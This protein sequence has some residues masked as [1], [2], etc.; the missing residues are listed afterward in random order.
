[1]T[2]RLRTFG[3]VYIE[4]DGTPLGGAHSQRRRLAL[5]AYLAAAD[6]VAVRREKLIALLWPESDESSA[7]HSL[8]QLLYALRHDLG[9]DAIAVDAETV[10]LDPNVVASDARDFEQALREGRFGDAVELYRGAFLEDFHV[11]DAPD[12]DRWI[13]TER[14]RLAFACARALDR[15]AQDAETS[16][17]FHRAVEWL[18]RRVALDPADAR[19]TLK[20]MQA[21]AAIGDRDGALRVARVYQS[22]LRDEIEAEPDPAIGRFMEELRRAP[23]PDP[24]SAA[25]LPPAV[26]PLRPQPG[27]SSSAP[28]A[29]PEPPARISAG[30]RIPAR[31]V[32]TGGIA[33][34]LL[35]VATAL[36]ARSR[37]GASARHADGIALVVIGD[38]EGPDGA[39]ALAVR[40][41]L[42]AELV[43][44]S[45]VLLTSDH[46]IR[47]LRTLMRLP[48]DAPLRP[49]A[50]LTLANRA[51]A[52]VAITGSVVPV[53][54]GAQI[55]LELLD[56]V[57]MRPI[58]TFSER[59]VDGA[60]TLAAVDRLA[61]LI[62][63][64]VSRAPRDTSVR[65]LPAVTTSSLPALK[66]Y[67]QARQTAARGK[68]QEAIAPA[69]R[70]VTHD[71][72][73][74]LAHYLLGDVLW[75]LDEQT[76]SEAHLSKAYELSSTVPAREQLVI[77]ARYEQLAR[78]RPDSALVYWQMVADAW[79]GDVHAYEGRS[80]AL[81]AL[82]RHEEAAAAADTAMSLDPGALL[83]NMTNAMYSWLSVGDTT[84]ALDVA[85]R[86]ATRYPEA[87]IEAR[88]YTA[89]YRNPAEALAWADSAALPHTRRW[90]RHQA[91][92]ATGDVAGARATLDSLR[93]DDFMAIVPNAHVH[94]GWLELV[95]GAGPAAA[96][97]HAREALEW[98][99]ARDA[100]PPGVARL[101]ER[102]ADL[103]ARA[104]D[105]SLV[106]ATIALVRERD[107]GRSLRTYEMARKT[108][109]AALAYV[110][111]DFA[112]AARRAEEARHGI[113]FSRSLATVVQ[114]EADARRAAGQLGAA[115]SLARLVSTHQI[116]DGHFEAWLILRSVTA[117]AA[118]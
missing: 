69:E 64:D 106:R 39:L 42:R 90:R 25:P 101:A 28:L 51:G 89:M 23:S 46:G 108:L 2:L 38:L 24:A 6:A 81:R 21:L 19:A 113:Y 67:A 29:V 109:D 78:D 41:G 22:L 75:F 68:R 66:S 5:L 105:E 94:Q 103:A 60:S 54:E 79:P 16:R 8:S 35:L 63:R 112:E 48:E 116:V 96:A 95:R 84:S 100:S 72:T 55:V 70:A 61:R 4:R 88:F 33:L 31:R 80:W 111:G 57:S 9:A 110:R 85:N 115:D 20:L 91:Q 71:S 83:P 62:G 11:D 45:G 87:L 17:D 37:N 30:A 40:E 77:R 98:T 56:P 27:A 73:F 58:R 99:R 49:P 50:L 10:R 53:G 32:L 3:A 1:M 18:R 97:R 104:G 52:H 86:L 59:P 44:T 36:M 92:V 114:L 102:I 82:G 13:D 93:S 76:H 15:L 65:P 7:R 26:P 12:L 107:R 47:E 118:R 117:L 14:S 74:V 34:V 43:N